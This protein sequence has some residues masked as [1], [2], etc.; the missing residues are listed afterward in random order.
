MQ[1]HFLIYTAATVS[2]AIVLLVLDVSKIKGSSKTLGD[3]TMAIRV[4]LTA[5]FSGF[6]ILSTK[7]LSSL[8]GLT[9]YLAF[10]YWI[11]YVLVLAL[12]F[13]SVLTL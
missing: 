3:R 4:C 7:G 10:T 2:C 6:T 9:L 11:T 8:L 12:I 1:P 5:I 13:N